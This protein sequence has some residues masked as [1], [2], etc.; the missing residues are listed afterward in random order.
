MGRFQ[1]K[2]VL[3]AILLAGLVFYTGYRMSGGGGACAP[4]W[5]LAAY[6][7]RE[8]GSE[9]FAGKTL[10]LN[11]W[12]TYCGPCVQETQ[13]LAEL[14]RELA[15]PDLAVLG[16]VMDE[17]EAAAIKD[18]CAR[19]EIDYP[20]LRGEEAVAERFGGIRMVPTTFVIAPDGRI[21]EVF[22]GRAAPGKLREAVRAAASGADL[23]QL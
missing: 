13:E 9:D 3:V 8:L 6:D 10:V 23:A 20:M 1:A 2:D 12:A 5:D 18:Y 21:A 16:V 19:K 14:E 4:A 17:P 7:G 22:E 15:D 11:F